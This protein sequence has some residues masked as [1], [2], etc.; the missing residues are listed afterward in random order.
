MSRPMMYG[1]TIS[2]GCSHAQAHAC[3]IRFVEFKAIARGNNPLEADLFVSSQLADWLL[4]PLGS[5]VTR[6]LFNFDL[7]ELGGQPAGCSGGYNI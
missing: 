7:F 4:A 6:N 2:G 1:R 5:Q 3:R